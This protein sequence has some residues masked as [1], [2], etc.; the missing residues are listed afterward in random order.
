M[1]NPFEQLSPIRRLQGWIC[2]LMMLGG[3]IMMGA[4]I[5][6]YG[7]SPRLW[8]VAVGGLLLF[9]GLIALTFG[10]LLGAAE[11]TM[12]EQC[13]ELRRLN[14]NLS[15]QLEQLET[16]AEN[17]RI[18]DAAKALA[19][20]DQELSALRQAIRDNVATMRWEAAFSLVNEMEQRFGYRDEAS[21]V[22]QEL[23][24]ERDGAI[25]TKLGEAIVLVE[26]HFTSYEWERAAYEI[27][28]LRQIFP[29]NG[30]IRALPERMKQLQAEHKESLRTAWED[31]VRR[32][33]TDQA[34]DV[35]RHLDPYLTPE[36]GQA[37]RDAA[38]NVFKEKL[39]QLGVQFR[40]A[41]REK[42]WQ[43][44]LDTG[45]ELVREFPNARMASEVRDTLDVLRE[46]AR[47]SA[48]ADAAGQARMSALD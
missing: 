18:S 41:V 22:R 23:E 35:L 16:I 24:A 29:D 30:Q 3:L 34:I 11:A 40:F 48:E 13:E 10:P 28:R 39:L 38:R 7:D 12:Y 17:T 44:A 32:N 37:L 27:D 19:H 1:A 46:R 6:D 15:L 25:K 26:Q 5:L 21:R 14:R 8:V 36:E 31:A 20:R 33:D 9:A 2:V 43:D 45:L 47:V 42:R 4:G